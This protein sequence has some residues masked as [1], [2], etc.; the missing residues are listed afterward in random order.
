M[1]VEAGKLLGRNR[2]Y[3]S[4]EIKIE[5]RDETIVTR[6]LIESVWTPELVDTSVRVP[7]LATIR[8]PVRAEG[9]TLCPVMTIVDQNWVVV[10][11]PNRMKDAIYLEVAIDRLT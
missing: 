11:S 1:W 4:S 7:V 10:A 6:P 8:R 5:V 2:V 3:T 9:L